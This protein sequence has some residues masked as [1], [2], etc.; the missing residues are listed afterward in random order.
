MQRLQCELART[1]DTQRED[2]VG[3]HS[4]ERQDGKQAVRI[5]P[6]G[7]AL[8]MPRRNWRVAGRGRA[9]RRHS[10]TVGATTYRRLALYRQ[11]GRPAN[12]EYEREAQPLPQA[13]QPCCREGE[14]LVRATDPRTIEEPLGARVEKPAPQVADSQDLGIRRHVT[15]K[16]IKRVREQVVLAGGTELLSFDPREDHRV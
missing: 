10:E 9:N 4:G 6:C 15:S 7:A 8:L 11:S 16:L 13:W 14:M 12:H 2:H 3:G 5:G 1:F